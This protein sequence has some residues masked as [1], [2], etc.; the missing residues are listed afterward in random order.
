MHSIAYTLASIRQHKVL[1]LSPKPDTNLSIDAE[2]LRL[3]TRR[4]TSQ[5]TGVI[6]HAIRQAGK[7][8][9]CQ[10]QAVTHEVH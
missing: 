5:L 7:P 4:S 2:R 3:L 1:K 9:H 8:Q 6:D 10:L